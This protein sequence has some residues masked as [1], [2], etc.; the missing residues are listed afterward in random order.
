MSTLFLVG[1]YYQLV[2]VLLPL[3]SLSIHLVMTLLY[4]VYAVAPQD[5]L[6]LAVQFA[7]QRALIIMVAVRV[8]RG[9]CFSLEC[10]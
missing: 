10:F 7:V 4:A 9:L 2:I 6:G 1:L 3:F 5:C 8:R